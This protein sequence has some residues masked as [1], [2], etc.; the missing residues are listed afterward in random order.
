MSKG[1]SKQH[2]QLVERDM[3]GGPQDVLGVLQGK[4][5][6]PFV[7]PCVLQRQPSALALHCRVATPQMC[8]P[9]VGLHLVG[10][11]F[12]FRGEAS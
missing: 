3:K 7:L 12:L 1:F 10:V 2:G 11:M 5:H 8:V 6:L 9:L 4:Y